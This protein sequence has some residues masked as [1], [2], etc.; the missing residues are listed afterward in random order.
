MANVITSGTV[1]CK[2]LI[3]AKDK[4][5]SV[6][7]STDQAR[8]MLFFVSHRINS[9]GLYLPSLCD[10]NIKPI[11]FSAIAGNPRRSISHPSPT[12]NSSNLHRFGDNY[13]LLE[14][15][16][17]AVSAASRVGKT[18]G[19]GKKQGDFHFSC[20]PWETGSVLGDFGVQTAPLLLIYPI[21]LH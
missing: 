2:M 9:F 13:S 19:G 4:T 7:P 15:L 3:A 8:G 16:W 11:I 6:S 1:L 5:P 12:P 20:L 10:L 14:E 21:L 17:L 18:A